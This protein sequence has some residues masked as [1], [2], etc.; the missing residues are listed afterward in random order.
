MTEQL[1]GSHQPWDELVAAHA[2]HAL[3]PTEELRL[4]AHLD[5]CRPCRNRLDEF[6][7]VAAQLGS[8]ADDTLDP[9][10]WT[11]VRPHLRRTDPS[12]ASGNVSRVLPRQ[13]R[14]AVRAVTA[15]AAGVVVAAGAATSWELTRPGPPTSAAALTACRQQSGCRIVAL[16]GQQGDSAAVLVEAGHASLV[17]TNL[18]LPPAGRMYVLWQLPRDGS[19][20]PVV[21]FHDPTRQTSSVPLV[22]GYTDTAAFAVSLEIAGPM[23]THPTDV[24]AVGAAGS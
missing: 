10:A 20:I 5:G 2:L 7:L 23:P 4:L 6:T 1:D 19:P 18:P 22:T 16:H 9:P 17:P 21:T 8:L 11:D 24:L 13:R 12:A 15:A 14:V 3:E